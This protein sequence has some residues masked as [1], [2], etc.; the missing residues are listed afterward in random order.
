VTFREEFGGRFQ[1]AGI[2]GEMVACSKARSVGRF[3]TLMSKVE[4]AS[5]LATGR[6]AQEC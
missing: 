1:I 2:H 5:G 3:A 4:G 6:S